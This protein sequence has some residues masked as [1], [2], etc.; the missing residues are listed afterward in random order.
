[1]SQD[2]LKVR[3]I[4]KR[5]GPVIALREVSMATAA[6]EVHALLGANGAGKSTLVK[7]LT[8]VV[9]PDQGTIEVSGKSVSFATPT[10]ARSSGL[11]SVF[12]DPALAPDLTVAQNMRLTGTDIDTFIAHLTSFGLDDVD[13]KATMRDVPLTSQR[14]IDLA[15]A[16]TF[17]P[18][19]LLLDEIT[20]ALPADLSEKVFMTMRQRKEQGKSVLFITHRLGE[21]LEHAD[22]A[23]ILRD[24]VVVE[25]VDTRDSNETQLVTAMVGEL[26]TSSASD[27]RTAATH[28]QV[29]LA[30]RN[31]ASG[32]RLHDIS[33]DLH[34]GEILGVAAL[35]GQGQEEFFE[36]LA[37]A[38]K[39]TGG[40]IEVEG[41]KVR[42]RSPFDAVKRGIALVP[43]DRQEALLPLQSIAD[44]L[45]APR[46]NRVSR[47]GWI[48]RKKE[49]ALVDATVE[50]LQIDTRAADAVKQLSG[51]N[52]QKV[53][54]GRWI[55]A[56]FEVLLTFDP[57]RG[58]DARTKHQIY[59]LLRRFADEGKSVLFF[60]SE[61]RELQIVADRVMVI[62]AGRVV[63]ELGADEIDEQVILERMHGL[64]AEE[65]S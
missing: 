39:S 3:D 64:S 38:R 63:A 5:Y 50:E 47:W 8:G 46:H 45:T 34:K 54:I 20:A 18:D 42:F 21:V 2:L 43:S 51:G 14:M 35:D 32:R 44:N 24:G 12:Q 30:G 60:T 27:R 57:T 52:Q 25:V 29:V 37:G 33:F 4:A 11:V 23:T 10:Q 17:D 49:G 36:V 59:P 48:S 19:V 15:R 16:L 56:G 62:Y 55:T 7:I 13:L 28:S 1:M 9:R 40:S 26:D 41:H 65:A 31:I 61:L 58:I 22:R 6:G 53:T